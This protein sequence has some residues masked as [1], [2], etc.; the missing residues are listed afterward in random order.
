MH[1]LR[2]YRHPFMSIRSGVGDIQYIKDNIL[3]LNSQ[4]FYNFSKTSTCG[5][6]PNVDTLVIPRERPH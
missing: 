3:R 2:K 4:A 1:F 5:Q 6:L